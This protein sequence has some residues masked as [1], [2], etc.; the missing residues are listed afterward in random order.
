MN[1]IVELC[2]QAN[3]SHV[4]VL[5]NE[6][7]IIIPLSCRSCEV[8]ETYTKVLVSRVCFIVLH[9]PKHG[10]LVAKIIKKYLFSGSDGAGGHLSSCIPSSLASHNAA[11]T[12]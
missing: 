1:G 9:A 7:I 8:S 6:L 5:R 3:L 2:C 11:S 12:Q 4:Q 10:G